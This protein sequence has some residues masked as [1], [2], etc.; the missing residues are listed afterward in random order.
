MLFCIT[1]TNNDQ[2]MLTKAKKPDISWDKF[3]GPASKKSHKVS[4]K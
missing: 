4:Q 3:K 2:K 1:Y